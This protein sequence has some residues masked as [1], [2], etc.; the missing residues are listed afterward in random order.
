MKNINW[1]DHL[2]NFIS[3]IVGVFLAFQIGSIAE[4]NKDRQERKEILLSFIEDLEEDS[5][6]YRD[7]Q[8]PENE[9]Q[10]GM[11][12]KLLISILESHPDSIAQQ[13]SVAVNV[14]NHS[15]LSATYNSV[16]STGKLGL[17]KDFEAK[18][19]LSHYYE[20]LSMESIKQGEVQVEFFLRQIIPWMVDNTNI[21]DVDTREIV[22][23]TQFENRLVIYKSLIDNK[24][25][26]YKS[27]SKASE[28]LQILLK[29]LLK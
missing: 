22:G 10:S 18:K 1:P 4:K 9:N 8:I 16:V 6:T 29:Y 2:I 5:K 20:A 17:I 13:M 14:K 27:I 12:E 19:K 11:I 25:Q 7:F 24:I 28:E 26:Q 15:P 21:M 23:D 3:V